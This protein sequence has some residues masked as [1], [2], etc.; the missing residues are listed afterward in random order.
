MHSVGE[1]ISKPKNGNVLSQRKV[2]GTCICKKYR[3]WKVLE[4]VHGRYTYLLR[5]RSGFS[6]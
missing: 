5:Y 1:S 2:N 3:G 4:A 6:L